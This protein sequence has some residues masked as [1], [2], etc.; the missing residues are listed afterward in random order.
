MREQGGG[1]KATAGAKAWLNPHQLSCENCLN[2]YSPLLGLMGTLR[3]ADDDRSFVSICG[4]FGHF[5][6]SDARGPGVSEDPGSASGCSSNISDCLHNATNAP[7]KSS[8]PANEAIKPPTLNFS[9]TSGSIPDY[10]SL[11]LVLTHPE[12]FG[13]NSQNTPPPSDPLGIGRVLGATGIIARRDPIPEPASLALLGS[14][15]LW[16]GL[17]R[18][19]RSR[20]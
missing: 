19:R 4:V 15:L 1:G 3:Y 9:V 11:P 18:R 6:C 7:D 20:L 12:F 14:A 8:P 17:M 13:F 5:M 2:S 10:E 16:F